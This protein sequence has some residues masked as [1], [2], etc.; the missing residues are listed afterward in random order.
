[1]PWEYLKARLNTWSDGN[2]VKVSLPDEN[3]IDGKAWR[4]A[5]ELGAQNWELVSIVKA[6]E[7]PADHAQVGIFKRFTHSREA[8]DL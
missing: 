5:N 1:M 7:N 8:I 6:S 4:N 3:G 2:E